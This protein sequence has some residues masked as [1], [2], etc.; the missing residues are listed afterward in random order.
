MLIDYR[1]RQPRGEDV[2][3]RQTETKFPNGNEVYSRDHEDPH[4]LKYST[5]APSTR[6][7]PEIRITLSH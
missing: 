3:N 7:S 1:F 5:S 2:L 6:K 4:G